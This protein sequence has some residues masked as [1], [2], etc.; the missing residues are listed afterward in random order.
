M[1]R[2]SGR[3]TDYEWQAVAGRITT[4]DLAEGSANVGTNGMVVSVPSTSM[5]IRGEVLVQLDA[6]AVDERACIAM[7]IIK[8]SNSAFAAGIGSIPNPF[9]DAES[10]WVWHSF[11][12]VTSMAEA[13]VG[14]DYIA[15]RVVIDS[16][17][18][19]KCKPNE[20][21]AF[22]AEVASSVDATGSVDLIYGWRQ[23]F[24][25]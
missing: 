5:R 19:R 14:S 23:L 22:V 4:L 13:A 10:E 8:V 9:A 20:T 18:M 3:R 25:T 24:G 11:T 2:S 15:S 16:K 1:A 21:F 7:G 12:S 6:G 17:A